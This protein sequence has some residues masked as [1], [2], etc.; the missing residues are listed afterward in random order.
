M[1]E[2]WARRIGIKFPFGGSTSD[3]QAAASNLYCKEK[4]WDSGVGRWVRRQL[5]FL[6]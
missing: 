2:V 5:D 1:L 3:R 4:V 6:D